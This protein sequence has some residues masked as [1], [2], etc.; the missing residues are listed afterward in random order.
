[1]KTFTER[2]K[3]VVRKIPK[4]EVLTYKQIAKMAGSSKA[5]R[6]VGTIMSKNYD[7]KI[8]C[9]RVVKTDGSM[10]G[11]NRGGVKKKIDILKKEGVLIK[12]GRVVL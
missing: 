7:L 2:V 11:Y 3:D 8:P 4:G 12:N 10:A 6:A 9:H 1:M 5:F